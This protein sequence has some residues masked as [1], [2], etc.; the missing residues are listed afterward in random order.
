MQK[1]L[2]PIVLSF[3]FGHVKAQ[4]PVVKVEQYKVI[5]DRSV[6]HNNTY[7]CYKYQ[8]LGSNPNNGTPYFSAPSPTSPY[9]NYTGYGYV[10]DVNCNYCNGGNKD[11]LFFKLYKNNV[12][13]SNSSL[14][15]NNIIASDIPKG[16][17]KTYSDTIQIFQSQFNITNIQN[18]LHQTEVYY[19]A[20]YYYDSRFDISCHPQQKFYDYFTPTGEFYDKAYTYNPSGNG[21]SNRY[22]L[23]TRVRVIPNL[24]LTYTLPSHDKISMTQTQGGTV[25]Q[26]QYYSLQDG[27]PWINIPSNLNLISGTNKEKLTISAVDLF[28]SNYAAYLNSNILIRAVLTNNAVSAPVTF[29]IRLSSPHIKNVSPTHLNCYD[30]NEGSIKLKFDRPLLTGE[31]LNVLLYDTLNRVNYSA[32]NITQFNPSDSSYTWANELGAGLYSVNLLGKYAKGIEYDLYVNNREDTVPVYKALNSVNFEDGFNTPPVT[33]FNAYTDFDGYSQPTYT[34]G[35]THFAYQQITQPEKIRFAVRVDSNVFCKGTAAGVITVAADGGFDFPNNK[36]YYKYSIKHNDSSTFSDFVNFTNTDPAYL[37]MS[38]PYFFSYRGVS[39]KIRNLKAGIYL[40]YLRDSVDCFAK[41]SVGNEV[42][43]AFTITEPEKGITAEQLEISPITAADSANGSFN[44][45]ISGGTSYNTSVN[46]GE[47]VYDEAYIVQLR[48]SATNTLLADRVHYTDTTIANIYNLQTGKLSEGVYILK[49]FDKSYKANDPFNAGCY[50]EVHI[51]FVQPEPLVVDILNRKQI[52]CYNDRDGELV[53]RA[54]GGIQNDTTRYKFQW[55]QLR[56]EGNIV[57]P[58]PTDTLI[59][60]KDSVITGLKTGT[61]RVEITDKYNNKKS[62]TFQL[63]QPALMQLQFATTPASCYTSFDG[64]MSVTV[65]GGSPYSDP[66]NAYQYEWSNGSLKRVVDSVAGGNYLLVVRDSMGCIAK[67]TVNITSP[68]RV[69]AADTLLHPV[70]CYNSND[71]SLSV[72]ATGGTGTYT[73]QWSNGATTPVISNL[74]GGWYSYKVI[75]GN[76]CFDSSSI[77]LTQP[78]TILVNLGADRLLCKG[79]VLRLNAVIA[80]ATDT[81]SYVWS[82][83][84]NNITSNGAKANITGSGT[85]TL[86]VSNTTGCTI[87]DT[88]VVNT[89]ADSVN[90]DFIVSTQAYK[91]ESVILINLSYPNAQ[92]S[93]LWT[94]PSFGNGVT[95]QSQ[96]YLNAQVL[97]TDTGRY[98]LGMKVYYRNGC[99]DDTAK[100]VNVISRDNINNPGNGANA[101]LKLY[102]VIIPNPSPGTF[103]VRLTLSE[104]TRARLRVVNTLTNV[105]VDA[106]DITITEAP[107]VHTENYSLSSSVLSGVYALVIETPKGNFVYKLVIAR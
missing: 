38:D 75:D 3:L 52:S 5:I 76:G 106:R 39:Q 104:N 33:D 24:D 53:A 11:T 44:I 10:E 65:N 80:S 45:K 99:I 82:G 28:G 89:S 6:T 43:Y 56:T 88:I 62:D 18:E 103:A 55:Y 48:D 7:S 58:T 32:F 107:G 87:R 64:S 71:G 26:W 74:A 25:N 47:T 69:I 37:Y 13:Q 12:L 73:Y 96:T 17:T 16:V 14:G 19:Y 40:M 35:L 49:V 84:A 51:R 57:L 4:T 72:S 59:E 66:F 29:T 27:G 67:D 95:L 102:A 30:R 50:L 90:T 85:Y 42:T 77:T 63:L 15:I 70:T 22:Q 101:Y 61:Y 21:A 68:V 100:F 41:D 34:G 79:Q 94:I 9:H 92:D 54:S 20:S 97:F 60:V 91:N 93:V 105:T 31:K 36:K 8:Y 81:L 83:T 23:A 46:G 1:F 86:A 2:L 98:E 78:D